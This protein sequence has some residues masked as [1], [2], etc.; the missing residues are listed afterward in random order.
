MDNGQRAQ[1]RLQRRVAG[2]FPRNRFA[3][4]AKSLGKAA[5]SGL[6]IYSKM[7]WSMA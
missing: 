3:I 4:L 6:L 7:V 2:L 1:A 5:M